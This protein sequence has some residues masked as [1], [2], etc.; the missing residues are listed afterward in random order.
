MQS[1]PKFVRMHMNRSDVPGCASPIRA[2]LGLVEKLHKDMALSTLRSQGEMT[3]PD[4]G[5][6]THQPLDFQFPKDSLERKKLLADRFS[7]LGSSSTVG[8]TTMRPEM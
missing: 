1:V 6:S 2:L 7:R 4:I 3:L 5:E 8:Y